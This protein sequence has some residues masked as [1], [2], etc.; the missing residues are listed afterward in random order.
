MGYPEAEILQFGEG[1]VTP[2]AYK[3]TEHYVVTRAFLERPE[4]MLRELMGTER[5]PS[6]KARKTSD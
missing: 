3:D 1:V 4:H 6:T 5:K 2:V